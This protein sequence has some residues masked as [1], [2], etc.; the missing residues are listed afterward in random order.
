MSEEKGLNL[1]P[2]QLQALITAAVTA[3]VSEAKKPAPLTEAQEAQLKQDIDMRRQ[4]AELQLERIKNEKMLRSVCTHTRKDRS[5]AT[6]H[7]QDG[8]YILCQIC[9]AIVRPAPAPKDDDGRSIYD[10]GLFNHLVQSS[11]AAAT[12]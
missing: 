1:T 6:V 11:G 3:A 8:N 10:T 9:Q 12:I 5:Y 4:T 7:V 2:T